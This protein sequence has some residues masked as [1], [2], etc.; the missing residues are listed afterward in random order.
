[1]IETKQQVFNPYLPSWEY[2]PDGEPYVF[3][4][5]VYIY[6]SHDSFGA[7]IFCVK[8]YV[9]WSAPLDDLSDWKYEGVIYQKKQ[10]PSNKLG[11]RC[12]YAPDV[13]HGT[14]GRYYLYY[15]FDFMGEMGVAVCDTPAGQYEFY[16][17]VHFKDGHVW[18]KKSG[19]PFPFDPG[20]LVD[21][22]GRVYLYSGFA[23]KV[24]RIASRGH[25]LTNEGGVVLEL[26]QDMLTIKSGPELLF[27]I[28]GKEGA[29]ENHAFFEASS[30]RKIDGKYCFV[31]SSEHNHDLCY[32]MADSPKGPFQ[33]GGRLVDLG[34]LGID[35]N[36]D[37]SHALNYL[38]NTHGGM[39]RLNGEWYI[40]Y[41]RQTNQSSYARQACAERLERTSD[42]GFKQAEITS[43]GLNGGPLKG[44]GR[45]EARIACNLWSAEGTGRYDGKSPKKRLKNHPYFTQ[46]GK[47]REGEGDQYI[48]NFRDG[49]VAGFK[50]FQMGEANQVRIEIRGNATGV[51][52]VSENA[53]FLKTC[54]EIP[55]TAA[56]GETKIYPGKLEIEEGKKAL[57][58]RY[59]G[60]GVLDFLS[61]E[62]LKG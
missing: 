53:E 45:Y 9:C 19:E 4:D 54:A 32:A 51:M 30:I 49:S 43:C 29:F 42:G 56:G 14:D 36:E 61:F 16:G 26:E 18:G 57:F 23:T 11:L 13:A 5:R 8:D 50:Y 27:P 22:D 7:P 46:S 52:Q 24:P 2:V 17:H 31:Y 60:E 47:D 62:L 25:N 39:A 48:A 33:F 59:K 58:F 38:G 35:G 44:I 10:D 15:A 6:G 40:F 55:F 3:G 20:V 21:D 12:L 41:H 34:D 1:M 37:E 28:K